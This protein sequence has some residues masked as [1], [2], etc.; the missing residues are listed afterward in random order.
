MVGRRIVSHSSA[1]TES[2]RGVCRLRIPA[3]PSSSSRRRFRSIS[4][5]SVLLRVPVESLIRCPANMKSIRHVLWPFS[6]YT[7]ISIPLPR[8]LRG[9][10]A[11]PAVVAGY[12]LQSFDSEPFQTR[13]VGPSAHPR[14]VFP[15]LLFRHPLYPKQFR[16]TIASTKV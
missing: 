3:T 1:A 4:L 10:P 12:L 9:P 2:N 15:A 16:L 7:D 11:L 8:R 6:R 14:G 13:A 5:A